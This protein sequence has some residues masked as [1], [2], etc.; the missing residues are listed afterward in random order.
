MQTLTTF[1]ALV[2]LGAPA[3]C[4]TGGAAS[5]GGEDAPLAIDVSQ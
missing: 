4:S 2:L 1:L 3:A 5:S